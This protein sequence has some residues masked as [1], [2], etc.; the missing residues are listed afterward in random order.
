[1]LVQKEFKPG[2]KLNHNNFTSLEDGAFPHKDILRVVCGY[3]ANSDLSCKR[4]H[5]SNFQ[6]LLGRSNA[7]RTSERR[8]RRQ[9]SFRIWA[10]VASQTTTVFL[11]GGG[12]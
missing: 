8:D 10:G 6:D 9:R 12:Y 2:K 1:M 11:R 5:L 3:A 4:G 7:M